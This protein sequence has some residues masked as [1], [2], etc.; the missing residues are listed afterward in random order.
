MSSRPNSTSL[1]YPAGSVLIGLL[2]TQVLASLHVYLSNAEL[3][4]KVKLIAEAGYVAVP[5]EHIM[6]GLREFNPAFFGG[7]FFTLSL[8][9]G[10]S[11]F[12]LAGAW[13]WDRL[14]GR[15][16]V[17]LIPVI[18]LWSAAIVAVNIKEFCPMVTAYFVFIPPVV[19][20][21]T[22]KWMPQ[23]TG[24][25]LWLKLCIYFLPVLALAV[26][27]TSQADRS[28][29]LN[30]R[31]F[32]LLSNRVGEKI[33]D[34]YYRYT[35]YPAQSFK[36][37]DQKLLRTCTL[38]RVRD[39]VVARRIETQ[40]L[41]YDYLPVR[42]D[43]P[44][45]LEVSGSENTL[46]FKH[47]GIT[48]LQTTLKDF[49][50]NPRKVLTDFSIKTDRFAVFRLAT[51]FSLLIGFPLTLYII[52]YAMFRFLLRCFLG[53]LSSSAVAAILCFST[54]LASLVPVYCGRA[55]TIN[56]VQLPEAL[57]SLQWQKRVAA[58]RTV[59]RSGQDIGNFPGYR[60]MLVSRH[61]PER[62]WLAKA[63]GVSRRPETYQDLLALLDD[64]NANVVCMAFQGLGQRGDRRAEKDILK[65]IRAS[66]HWYEQW[67]AYRALRALGWK[68]KRSK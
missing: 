65:R 5:N 66:N 57:S 54:G 11:L 6:P 9:A 1:L 38:S 7:C 44:V 35:L 26:M 39:E 56:S 59:V 36:S 55:E 61:V 43:I 33:N 32:L 64:P 58:L 42:P 22:L 40:L 30:I 18:F 47:E 29:F 20:F 2:A 34:F 45:D 14:C 48:V 60:R 51:I 31:D 3:Y 24:E 53:S 21:F 27:W 8:G 16:R 10:L 62:Y 23:Q 19:F 15:N 17:V 52:G 28:L 41:R 37:L 68:Q 67:Y 4:R 46:V 49:L 63:L 25:S 13:A 50:Y 12:S